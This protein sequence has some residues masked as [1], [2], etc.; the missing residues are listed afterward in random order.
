MNLSNRESRRVV[1]HIQGLL[2]KQKLGRGINAVH[3]VIQ[4][5]HYVQI[6]TISVVERSHHHVL[7][8]RVPNYTPAM[9]EG[10]LS[11]RQAIF[12]YWFHAAAYLPMADYRYYLPIMAG[13]KQRQTVDKKL[14]REII[15]RIKAEGPLQSRDFENLSGHKSGGWWDWKPSKRALESLFLSGELM[16]RERRG[17]QKVYDLTENVLP[18]HVDMSWPTEQQRGHYYARR[19]LAALGVAQAKEIGY[20]R[21]TVKYFSNHNIQNSID[22]SL[23]EMLE[24]GEV[25]Q[26]DLNGLKYYCLS[27]VLARVPKKMGRK[28]MRFLSPFDNLVINRKRLLELFDFD[29]QLECY[30]PAEKRKYGYFTLPILFGDELIGR[31]DC[32]AERKQHR[33]RINNIWLEP[34]TRLN[35]KFIDALTLAL[36]SYMLDLGC[37]RISIVKTDSKTLMQQLATMPLLQ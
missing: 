24:S 34:K 19:M 6:D 21:S 27:D 20:A 2:R 1:L 3:R 10:L 5:I 33:L 22:S 25:T 35:E 14:R 28:H 13:Y 16:V 26:F 4:Q 32:K 17:F 15:S 9:L 29:Y 12:E 31:M 36:H 37:E 8:S 18:G 11:K 23:Q 30:V 7:H